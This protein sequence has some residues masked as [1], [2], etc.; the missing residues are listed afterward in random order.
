VLEERPALSFAQYGIAIHVAARRVAGLGA[1]DG[2][3]ETLN[4]FDDAQALS[5]FE[6]DMMSYAHRAQAPLGTRIITER[7]LPLAVQFRSPWIYESEGTEYALRGTD[8]PN[9]ART[10]AFRLSIA[11]TSFAR[12]SVA[13]FHLAL[14][15]DSGEESALTEYDLI[16]LSK[17]WEA[18]EGFPE[19]G[20]ADERDDDQVLFVVG[21][22]RH[23]IHDL[24]GESI[25]PDWTAIE[26]PRRPDRT[27]SAPEQMD[28]SARSPVSGSPYRVGTISLGPPAS[29]GDALFDDVQ[30]LRGDPSRFV[31]DLESERGRR[32]LAFGGI[33]Q[34]LLDFEEIAVDELRDVFEPLHLTTTSIL[35]FHKGTLI[36]AH[37]DRESLRGY[38]FDVSPY[39]V[40]PHAVSLHNEERLRHAARVLETAR[41]RPLRKS[42]GSA[43][44]KPAGPRIRHPFSISMTLNLIDEA[45]ATLAQVVPNVFHYPQERQLFDMARGS[46]G[47]EQYEQTVRHDL[48]TAER[49]IGIR[50]QRRAARDVVVALVLTALGAVLAAAAQ[51]SRVLPL[52]VVVAIWVA[53]IASYLAYRARE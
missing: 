38:P 32:L 39:L 16:K 20:S 5:S 31:L 33:V 1:L 52:T 25:G 12:S 51:E 53:V 27:T 40:V 11:R 10:R 46:R 6:R 19:A 50:Q 3:R 8:S 42:D 24:I 21:D 47:W 14:A 13:V 18:G 41:P 2:G 23:S 44:P 48:Q 26:A 28:D 15:P 7:H 36:S 4:P 9:G 30:Q 29:G 35:G 45:S 17:L 49:E 22:R 37:R 34:A 43:L